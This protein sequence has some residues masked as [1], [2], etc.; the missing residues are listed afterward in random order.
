V[1]PG[2]WCKAGDVCYDDCACCK[3]KQLKRDSDVEV[4]NPPWSESI[5]AMVLASAKV[6]LNIPSLRFYPNLLADPCSAYL[7]AF[8]PPP[9]HVQC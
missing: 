3:K 6:T 7:T 8:P 2:D 5:I 1:Q 4:R 9:Y